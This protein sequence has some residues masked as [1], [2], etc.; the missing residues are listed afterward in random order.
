VLLR[1]GQH[2]SLSDPDNKPEPTKSEMDSDW[3]ALLG[4]TDSASNRPNFAPPGAK[5]PPAEYSPEP[6]PRT[7][8]G[9]ASVSGEFDVAERPEPRIPTRSRASEPVP[10]RV[11]RDDDTVKMA[12]EPFRVER[13]LTTLDDEDDDDRVTPADP[14]PNPITE[15]EAI[16]PE[17]FAASAEPER[18][19]GSGKLVWI[20]GAIAAVVLLVVVVVQNSGDDGEREQTVANELADK[21]SPPPREQPREPEPEPEPVE[22]TVG[23]DTVG[24]TSGGETGAGEPEPVPE[25]RPSHVDP[26]DPSLI[27]PGTPEENVKAF[28]KLPVSIH[29]GPPVGGIGRSGIHVDAISTARGRDNSSCTE[30]TEKFSVVADEYVNVCFRVVHV[31]EQ[32]SLRVI[33]EKD[34]KV[35]RR[36]RIR[37]PDL[38]AYTTRAYL[39]LRPEYTGRWRVR[40]VPDGEENIDLAVAEF[41]ISE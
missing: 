17:F 1:L 22:T 14:Q 3:D 34:G 16:A 2:A 33:W 38:H 39:L 10:V 9:G 20:V 26:R 28:L 11:D 40:I 15:P 36:G 18:G 19:G 29:D 7:S 31:R 37:I 8:H 12:T 24:E 27:P 32:E 30:P 35:T 13:P 25:P 21:Q 5:R 41:E 4:A 6:T 23:T